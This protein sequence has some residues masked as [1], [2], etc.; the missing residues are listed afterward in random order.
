[1]Q[2]VAR[3][4]G[5]A[6][7]GREVRR[8]LEARIEAIGSRAAQA[9]CRPRVVS[10]EWL[11]P[12]MLGRLHCALHRRRGTRSRRRSCRR[13]LRHTPASTPTPAAR[14]RSRIPRR[15]PC[16]RVRRSRLPVGSL[17]TGGSG[18]NPRPRRCRPRRR[19]GPV[20]AGAGSEA[21]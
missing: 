16:R 12:I 6:E 20:D 7:A 5:R 19:K 13:S 4:L 9:G 8:Q 2:R 18:R 3:A 10:I 1:V 15:G 11:D 17:R 21:V 14:R